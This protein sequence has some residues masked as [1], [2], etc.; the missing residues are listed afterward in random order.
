MVD[1]LIPGPE[2]K[3]E[4]KY[5]HNNNDKSPIV[6]ILHP[7]PS[8]GGSMNTKIVFNLYKL[9]ANNGFST[10]RFNF[11]G[12]G[13]S[14]GKFDNGLGELAD[15]AAALECPSVRHRLP[16]ATHRPALAFAP[17]ATR[18]AAALAANLAGGAA[19]FGLW[20]AADRLARRLAGVFCLAVCGAVAAADHQQT[21]R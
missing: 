18:R 15:A 19:D 16:V 12:V 7:D 8:R 2:G 13:K 10:I 17:A 14:E 20:P 6:L 5:S 3:I 21:G 4:A 1:L 9:F 11:R